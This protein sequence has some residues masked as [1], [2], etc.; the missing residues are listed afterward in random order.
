MTVSLF[1]INVQDVM[2]DLCC[3]S[4]KLSDV[5]IKPTNETKTKTDILTWRDS[6]NVSG[7]HS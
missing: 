1:N 5:G 3:S 4:K 6:F 2:T 7:T